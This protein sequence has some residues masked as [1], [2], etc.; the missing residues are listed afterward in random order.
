MNCPM[1]EER[2]CPGYHGLGEILTEA[3]CGVDLGEACDS[4]GRARTL[5]LLQMAFLEGQRT[6][7]IDPWM[8]PEWVS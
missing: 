2:P 5:A 3:A 4:T 7:A 6:G 1:C 8:K